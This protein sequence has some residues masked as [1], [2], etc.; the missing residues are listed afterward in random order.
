VRVS[1]GQYHVNGKP[2]GDVRTKISLD[3]TDELLATILQAVEVAILDGGGEPDTLRHVTVEVL[4]LGSAAGKYQ[5]VSG[6]VVAT[7]G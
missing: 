2:V 1:H 5:P 6:K 7:H 4:F 3:L